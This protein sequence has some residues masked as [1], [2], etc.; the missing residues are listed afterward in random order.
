MII[1]SEC[2]GIQPIAFGKNISNIKKFIKRFKD[3]F[4]LIIPEK[5]MKLLSTEYKLEFGGSKIFRG[6]KVYIIRGRAEEVSEEKEI[7]APAVVEYYIGADNGFIYRTRAVDERGNL[8]ASIEYKDVEFNTEI[9]DTDFT[10]KV[11]KG[12]EVF[13]AS[14]IIKYLAP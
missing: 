6:K 12:A 11:P 1:K 8:V 9:P 5:I 14:E 7:P 10:F 2:V 3:S 13:E 4:S